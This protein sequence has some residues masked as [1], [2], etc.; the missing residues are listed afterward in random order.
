MSGLAGTED[1]RVNQPTAV[2]G[3]A[4]SAVQGDALG[5]GD[6]VAGEASDADLGA[7]RRRGAGA[8][9]RRRTVPAERLQVVRDRGDALRDRREDDDQL[10]FDVGGSF[11]DHGDGAVGT[12]IGD[13]PSQLMQG[14]AEADESER[15]LFIGGTGQQ[16]SG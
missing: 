5:G 7:D 9:D 11:F 10:W 14:D 16:R 1:A 15:V 12:E 2:S 8:G 4:I 6:R 3:L 13:P